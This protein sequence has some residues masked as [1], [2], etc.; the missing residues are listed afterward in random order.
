MGRHTTDM[1]SLGRAWA[2]GM[3]LVIYLI[4]GG[5]LGYGLDRVFHTYPTLMLI[6]GAFGLA[7][8]LLRFIREAMML[9]RDMART[10]EDLP[11]APDEDDESEE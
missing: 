11:P 3:D 4:A 5:L 6:M 8:G 7:A 9:N 1:S 10:V 2:I